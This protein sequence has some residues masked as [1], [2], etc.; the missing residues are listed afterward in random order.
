MFAEDLFCCT[1]FKQRTFHVKH[2]ILSSWFVYEKVTSFS[3]LQTRNMWMLRKIWFLLVEMAIGLE[4]EKVDS[5][6]KT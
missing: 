5:Q 4:E 1:V 2:K 3:F 6:K